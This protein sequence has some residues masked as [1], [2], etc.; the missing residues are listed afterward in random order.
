[1]AN[2]DEMVLLGAQQAAA[3]DKAVSAL[4]RAVEGIG[5]NY[6]DMLA[7]DMEETVRELGRVNGETVDMNTRDL[8]FERFCSGK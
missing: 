7:I 8:I 1:M 5:K 3:L 6:Q 2:F 4:E